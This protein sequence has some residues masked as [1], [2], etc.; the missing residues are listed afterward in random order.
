MAYQRGAKD[1]HLIQRVLRD[2]VFIDQRYVLLR[3]HVILA[4]P[5]TLSWLLHAE[6]NLSWDGATATA[7]VLRTKANLTVKLLSDHT[8]WRGSVTDQF[9]VPIDEKYATGKVGSNYITGKWTNQSHLTVDSA[10]PAREF[11]IFAVLWP[12]RGAKPAL[13]FRYTYFR[14]RNC[15]NASRRQK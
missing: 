5:A 11:I 1:P 10:E 3:D 7:F 14:G 4:R 2:L 8:H 6:K 13:S 9:P 15:H 12:E